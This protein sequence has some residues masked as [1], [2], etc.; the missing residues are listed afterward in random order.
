MAEVALRKVV[1]RYDDVEAVRGIDLDISDHEFIVLVG[2]SGC[3][4]ST[5]LRMIAGLE[6]ITDGDIMIGGDVVNDVPPKDR[7]IA[8]GFQNYAL[9]PHMTVAENMSFGLRLKHYPKAE[10]KAR[11]TEAARLLDI[12]DLIDRKPKQLSGGQRQ[13]VAMG[14]AIVRNPKV[15]LFDEPL[16]NLDAKLRVQMRIEIKKVHQKVRTTTVYVTHDQVEAMTLAD[17]VVVMNKGRIEQ[18]GTPNELYHKPATRF[19]AGFIGSP[20]MNFIPCRLED[21]GGKLN[22]RLTDRISFPLPPARAARYSALPR[23]E[24]L[25]LGIRPEHLTESH[26]H[27]EPGVETFDTVLD[28]TEP[29]GMETLVYFGLEG[30]PVCGRVDPNAGAKDGAPIRLAMDLNNMHLLNE[31]TGAVL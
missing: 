7:D 13:R 14:R 30:T 10:I 16:S 8:M 1:K 22:V 4:K 25:L 21:V 29:M 19:V 26:A 18:I 5:T 17:R 20:A 28:V 2:P 15:F 11:V 31:A 6:D 27:L 12:T 3:G 23:S 9:Y 24:N